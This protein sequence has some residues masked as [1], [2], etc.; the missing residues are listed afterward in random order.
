MTTSPQHQ[1]TFDCSKYGSRDEENDKSVKAL[2]EQGVRALSGM[3]NE[4]AGM[5]KRRL[6]A[7]EISVSKPVPTQG[8]WANMEMEGS[9]G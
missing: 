1:S 3:K 2:N 7:L 8:N 4:P 6:K 5:L 9:V